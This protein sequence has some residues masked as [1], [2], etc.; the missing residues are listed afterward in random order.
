MKTNQ[1]FK[2]Y[3]LFLI[4]FYIFIFFRSPEIFINGRYF[5]EEGAIWWSYSLEND[6]LNTLFFSPSSGGYFCMICNLQILFTKFLPLAYGPIFT[7]ISS[8]LIFTLP[9]F[10]FIILNRN[11]IDKTS[12]L[13]MSI[14]LLV[15]P[16]MNFIEVFANSISSPQYLAISIFIILIYG[17]KDKN[18]LTF[19]YF[20]IFVGFLSY[21]YSLFL[22]PCFIIKYFFE[23]N[24]KLKVPIYF[25]IF[26]SVVHLNVL[27]YLITQNSFYYRNFSSAFDYTKILNIIRHSF[28]LNIFT[29]KYYKEPWLKYLVTF[30]FIFFLF[31]F[32]KRILKNDILII[33][34][35]FTSQVVLIYFGQIGDTYYGRYA[36][37]AS[38]LTLFIFFEMIKSKLAFKIF[39]SFLFLSSIYNFN[40]QG[41]SYFIECNEYCIPWNEQLNNISNNLTDKYIHWPMG[42]GEPYWFTDKI[43]PKPNP[44]PYQ[45]SVLGKDYLELYD[46]NFLDILKNNLNYIK[47]LG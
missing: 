6:V 2:I 28:T 40:V 3:F 42:E 5:A 29:E 14:L 16:S 31:L 26:A 36:V 4:I 35:A 11:Y 7:A 33:L 25:G 47:D 18:L 15:L 38:T 27:I 37:V 21:Y 46:L 45:K 12:R 41:G 10:L 22:L 13:G 8:L 20:V 32:L 43:N 24:K 34:L 30:I 44:S 39:F 23:N 17:L 19:Q 9:S 1:D